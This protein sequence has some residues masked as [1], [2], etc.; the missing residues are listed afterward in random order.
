MRL[1]GSLALAAFQE[2]GTD[3]SVTGQTERIDDEPSIA[4]DPV[5]PSRVI[6]AAQHL[7][8]PCTYYESTDGGTT[9]S[10]PHVA[11]LTR[12][13]YVCYDVVAR[14][15]PDGRYFYLSY[16]S[17]KNY[18][19]ISDVAVFRVSTD[20]STVSGPFIALHHRLGGV[21][22][23]DWIDVHQVDPS[24]ASEVYVTATYFHEGVGCSM[25]F[26]RSADYGATWSKP[27]PLA[28]YPGCA[29]D[30]VGGLGVRALGGFGSTVLVCWYGD[31]TDGWGPAQGGGGLFDI[32]C[33][34]SVDGGDTFG[35]LV[36][37]VKGEAY[38]LPYY[39]CPRAHYQR[40]WSAMLFGMAIGPDGSA[41]V[42]YARDPSVNN[43]G[44]EC[45][46]VRYVRSAGSPYDAWTAPV[47]IA[48]GRQ[49]Q[50]FSAVTA[51][52]DVEGRC[53]I[54][55]AY[56]DGRN[57]PSGR[58]N[59]RYDLYRVAS[60]DCGA[61]WLPPERVTDVS[62]LADKEFVCD[63]I[64]MSVVAGRVHLVWTDRRFAQHVGDAGSDIYTDQWE[65]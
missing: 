34:T 50:S 18:A 64:D 28:K 26:G 38:E 44:G 62:S 20:F 5:D 8:G 17:I 27:R 24:R 11:P 42:T 4:V 29:F 39:S 49:A 23:K 65:S 9:W 48:G 32:I 30:E 14:A 15:S 63:Y 56:M 43:G 58:P 41:H 36:Y 21:I 31:G 16:L 7:G 19:F 52:L 53:R 57:S 40:I 59:Q 3:V 22:D 12:N 35:P 45:G 54:D 1:P 25:L 13:S 6:V 46:D 47:T 37:A 10:I 2:G 61:T 33:R 60:T 51:S 55:V